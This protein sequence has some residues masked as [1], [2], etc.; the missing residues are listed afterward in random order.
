MKK[1]ISI[2][3]AVALAALLCTGCKSSKEPKV[4]ADLLPL[5]TAEG[6]PEVGP[7][8]DL[9]LGGPFRWMSERT[10]SPD[11]PGEGLSRY[12]MIYIGEG[13]NRIFIIDKGKVIWKYD[14]GPGNE[15]DDIWMLKNGDLLYTRM[16]WAGKITP[17]KKEVWRYNCQPGEEI[18]TMQPIG[19]DKAWMLINGQN[20]RV[21]MFNHKTGETI[22]EKPLEFDDKGSHGQSRRMR[23]T[24]DGTWLLCCLSRN[25][26]VEYDKDWNVIRTME[27]NKPW[28]AIRLANGNTLITLEDERRTVEI[29]KNDKVVWEFSIDDLPE[30]YKLGDCQSVVR[31]QN[32]NTIFCS[33]GGIGRTPQL[34]EITRDKKVVWV[35]DDWKNLGPATAVQ[36]L[37]EKGWSENPG[38]FDR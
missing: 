16:Y 5:F 20:S 31:L 37:N 8:E 17:D 26:V 10:T 24:K 2:F 12:P 32:G 22:W 21:V 25:K 33:R 27:V 18:H 29:D 6:V 4:L 14:T 30:P 28:A 1:Y 19:D 38:D 9:N 23:Y 34:V 15:L 7:A 3:A 11:W 35:L 13:Y 36:I